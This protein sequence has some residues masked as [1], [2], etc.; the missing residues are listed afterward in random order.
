[1]ADVSQIKIGNTIY[2]IKSELSKT[3]TLTSGGFVIPWSPG[4]IAAHARSSYSDYIPFAGDAK[5]FTYLLE[6]STGIDVY[7]KDKTFI[8]AITGDGAA[9][10]DISTKNGRYFRLTNDHVYMPDSNVRYYI[11]Y[12]NQEDIVDI[13]LLSIQ[14]KIVCCGDSLTWGAVYTGAS[15]V[16]QAYKSYPDILETITGTTCENI[17]SSGYSSSDWWSH[18]NDKLNQDALYI[19]F[20][21]T[22]GGLTDTISTDCSGT[23]PSS[24]SNTNTGNYGKILQTLKNNDRKAVLI[25]V[26]AASDST[27]EITNSVIDQFSS[28]FLYPVIKLDQERENSIYHCYPSGSGSNAVHFNDYGYCWLANDINMNINKLSYTDKINIFPL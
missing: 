27:V 13:N 28:R 17:G 3:P 1:M 5:V 10:Y 19:I 24:F 26:Y 7:D 23:D 4:A 6:N 8:R 9:W 12:E 11:G 21:G 20:L 18:H 16:R 22:N 2:T 25:H 14:K 15:V